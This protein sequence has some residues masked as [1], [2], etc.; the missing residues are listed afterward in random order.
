MKDQRNIARI[1]ILIPR[2]FLQAY[3]TPPRK[4]NNSQ[5]GTSY[6]QS[7]NPGR[8]AAACAGSIHRASALSIEA[9]AASGRVRISSRAAVLVRQWIQYC[10][11]PAGNT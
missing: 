7:Q 6:R 11:R 2:D 9:L 8:N 5:V 10:S 3:I 4:F 1:Y